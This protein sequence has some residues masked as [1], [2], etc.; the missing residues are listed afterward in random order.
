M[1]NLE[2]IYTEYPLLK[3]M[4]EHELM[5]L[6][7]IAGDENDNETISA[8]QDIFKYPEHIICK[9]NPNFKSDLSFEERVNNT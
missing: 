4:N 1:K 8:I 9:T 3:H 2:Q 6:L 7:F 5:Q